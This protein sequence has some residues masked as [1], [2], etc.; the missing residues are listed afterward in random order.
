MAGSLRQRAFLAP[1]GHP[2][3]D[4]ARIARHHDIRPEP[5][6]LHH[7]GPETFDQRVGLAKEIE[8]LRDRCLVLEVELDDFSPA[9]RD[10]FQVLPGADAIE[11]DHLRAHVGKHH[12]G[13]RAGPD[14]GKFDDA[15]AA[16]RARGPP[17]CSL[18]L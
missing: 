4:Q 11:R 2:A 10:R 8:H 17:A 5:K 16:E 13:K 1:A 3:E 6:P 12:A 15:N 9:P 7:A 14:A 18:G